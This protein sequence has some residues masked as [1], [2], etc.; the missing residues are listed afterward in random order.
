MVLVDNLKIMTK[1]W[2]LLGIFVFSLA[3]AIGMGASI[4]HQKMIDDRVSKLHG[5]VETMHG[6]AQALEKKAAAGEFSREEATNRFR[7][8]IQNMWYDDHHNYGFAIGLDG[9]TL[10]NPAAP[11]YDGK[12][13][14]IKADNG[15]LVVD[16]L[17]EAVERQPEA[18]VA[19]RFPKPGQSEPTDKL[20]FIKRFDPW[21]VF[22]GTGAYIDDIEADFQA[23]LFRLGLVALALIV[24]ASGV[25][26][27]IS[28]NI[29]APLKSLKSQM[30]RLVAGDLLLTIEATAR[31]DEIG[32]MARAV[33][34]F[35]RSMIEADRLRAE[36]QAEQQYRLKRAEMIEASI[37][38]FEGDI[39]VVVSGV[40]TAAAEL[41]GSA[42]SLA[43]SSVQ[44]SRQSSAVAVAAEQATQNVETVAAAIEQV[45]GSVDEIGRRVSE[46]GQLIAAAV[47]QASGSSAEVQGLAASADKIGTVVRLIADIASQTNLLAL[48]ATIEAARAGEAGKGFAVVAA[49]VKALANQTARAT[50]EIS[51]QVNAIQAATQGSVRSI[52]GVALTIGDV[53]ETASAI[54]AAVEEQGA[55]TREIA[56]NILQAAQGTSEVSSNITEIAGAAQQ[57]GAVADHVLSS[58]DLLGRNS[59]VLKARVVTFLHEVRVA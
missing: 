51:A 37:A 20:A 55:A 19:Y 58:A 52:E 22:I 12:K 3:F 57:I 7:G 23:V 49:E 24:G 53:N 1:L 4:L 48:N 21:G 9:V 14:E 15:K 8:A 35:Q 6:L 43:A 27:L 50:E 16:M 42:Q 18:I 45:S 10:V 29:T 39:G 28:H 40:A 54:A 32:E 33:E 59:E 41:E 56:R 17:A 5:L 46:S 38:R 26:L 2:V 47:E 13:A 34:V 36:Q 11:Q 44:T 31:R 25:A 30:E